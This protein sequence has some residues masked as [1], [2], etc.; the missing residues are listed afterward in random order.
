MKCGVGSW[1]ICDRL[2]GG[3]RAS[4]LSLGIGP[5]SAPNAKFLLTYTALDESSCILI[6]HGTVRFV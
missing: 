4:W 2:R 5:H 6:R 3:T 1:D